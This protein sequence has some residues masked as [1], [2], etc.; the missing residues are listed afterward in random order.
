MSQARVQT[1]I[2]P[3][4]IYRDHPQLQR[5][6]ERGYEKNKRTGRATHNFAKLVYCDM[7]W[8]LDNARRDDDDVQYDSEDEDRD[9]DNI[10]YFNFLK[11]VSNAGPVVSANEIGRH[12]RTKL[13]FDIDGHIHFGVQELKDE[14]LDPLTD[15]LREFYSTNTGQD[16]DIDSINEIFTV[17]VCQRNKVGCF[18]LI[19]PFFAFTKGGALDEAINKIASKL[20]ADHNE[21]YPTCVNQ[22]DVIDM[23]CF[24]N[25]NL[26]MCYQYNNRTNDNSKG[27]YK[28]TNIFNGS[29]EPLS[30]ITLDEITFNMPTGDGIS[31]EEEEEDAIAKEMFITSLHGGVSACPT[32]FGPIEDKRAQLT[33]SQRN[34]NNKRARDDASV[35][36]EDDPEIEFDADIQMTD[37]AT[38]ISVFNCDKPFKIDEYPPFEAQDM[39]AWFFG[40]QKKYYQKQIDLDGAKREI[41]KELNKH[42]AWIAEDNFLV[43]R[44]YDQSVDMVVF[45]EVETQYVKTRL[46]SL[47]LDHN[48]VSR[49]QVIPP[50][51]KIK[52][53]PTKVWDVMSTTLYKR[54][55]SNVYFDPSPLMQNDKKSLNLWQG[56]RWTREQLEPLLKDERAIKLGMRIHNHIKDKICMGDEDKLRWLYSWMAN[57]IR[58]PHIKAQIVPVII[59]PEGNG[60][61]CWITWFAMIFGNQWYL[62]QNMD[63]TMKARFNSQFANKVLIVLEE[64]VWPGSHQSANYFKTLITEKFMEIEFKHKNRRNMKSYSN[65]MVISNGDGEGW[66]VPVS[67]QARRFVIFMT[68]KLHNPQIVGHEAFTQY[69]N[70][71]WEVEKEDF[72]GVRA[73]L[74][75]LAFNYGDTNIIVKNSHIE[76]FGMGRP[77]PDSCEEALSTQKMHSVDT[78]VLFWKS[79]LERHFSVHPWEDWI[80]QFNNASAEAVALRTKCPGGR[81]T[82]QP[83]PDCEFN[84]NN[85]KETIFHNPWLQ[86]VCTK[87]LY[88]VYKHWYSENERRFGKT[89][90]PKT[91][92]LTRTNELLKT[93]QKRNG[94][95]DYYYIPITADIRKQAL[96]NRRGDASV[97]A[98]STLIY[99]NSGITYKEQCIVL[100]HYDEAFLN[101][102]TNTKISRKEFAMPEEDIPVNVL[103]T[104]MRRSRQVVQN[105]GNVRN[106]LAEIIPPPPASPQYLE[107]LSPGELRHEERMEAFGQNQEAIIA[108]DS[109]NYLFL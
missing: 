62:A 67:E 24:N 11:L 28:I 84:P 45:K 8:I 58:Y 108:D 80:H 65:Y 53:A 83:Y 88:E 33:E 49:E 70:H 54:I 99:Q 52:L 93:D 77:T 4:A 107:E 37:F 38:A 23:Q 101:F 90:M 48:Q 92:F 36:G 74:A 105:L 47:I 10:D 51:K 72:L 57:R 12:H 98:E 75:M 50:K 15:C 30:S 61:S 78:A 9:D 5:L 106:Q 27:L 82:A 2:L 81:R 69:N 60:K 100:G 79:M 87:Q 46:Q 6:I 95:V 35:A 91:R 19:Y 89:L 55:Y 34:E 26:R 71:L 21:K 102:I 44:T 109:L 64:A 43:R 20:L 22:K 41:I 85:I 68:D 31:V 17:V 97:E 66:V 29:L 40:V 42:Y 76:T 3:P 14:V 56:L 7:R 96:L 73:W 16:L 63:S 32:S 13:A 25:Q 1:P 104:M 103:A 59:G 86:V 39:N 94:T 18:H